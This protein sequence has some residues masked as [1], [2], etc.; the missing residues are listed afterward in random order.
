MVTWIY[1]SV[2]T[3]S[4]WVASY[5][6]WI[7][8]FSLFVSVVGA[9]SIRYVVIQLPAD[10][11]MAETAAR[12]TRGSR[13]LRFLLS[14]ARNVV[15]LI[16]LLAGLIMSLP[17]VAGPGLLTVL[18]GLSIMNFPG[19]RKLEMKIV[20]QKTIRKS[21]DMIR[22]KADKPPLELPEDIMAE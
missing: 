14:L 3:I 16:L 21:I 9:I 2:R 4:H 22:T 8:G 11:F 18:L 10:Y 13:P 6:W 20:G 5:A 12:G 19:K 7:F 15:G 1:D 17:G